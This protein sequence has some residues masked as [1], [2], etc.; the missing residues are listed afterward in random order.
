M[1]PRSAGHQPK[2]LCSS[3]FSLLEALV[4]LTLMGIAM[5]MTMALLAEEPRIR[6]R[7]EAHREALRALEAVHE[8]IRANSWVPEDG[9]EI[10]LSTCPLASPSAAANLRV[11]ADVES[12]AER[13]LYRV[14]LRASYIVRGQAC[15]QSIETM[16]WR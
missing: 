14:T 1:R 2:V 8:N 13:N 6:Q 11:W 5:L 16:V 12:L 7:L 3:G 10:D 4:A 15:Q 9:E